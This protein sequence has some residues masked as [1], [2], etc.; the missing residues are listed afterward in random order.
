MAANDRCLRVLGIDPGLTGAGVSILAS[1]VAIGP[2]LGGWDM[3]TRPERLSRGKT[4][5]AVDA[6]RLAQLI[7]DAEPDLIVLERVHAAP[8]QGVASMFRFGRA[9]GI[10]E[11]AAAGLRVPL[12]EIL[13]REWMRWTKTA[14]GSSSSRVREHAAVTF[15]NPDFLVNAPTVKSAEAR[16]DAALIAA[17]G[18]LR[19]LNPR[20]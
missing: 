12:V 13:P 16:G 7:A 14:T 9:A 15:D 6:P 2:V 19:L 18:A 11:G 4:R 5:P 3:P 20:M 17:G 1:P 8:G 10:V